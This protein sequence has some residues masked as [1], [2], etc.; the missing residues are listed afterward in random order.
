M[1]L[2]S[3]PSISSITVAMV[4]PNWFITVIILIEIIYQYYRSPQPTPTG[5]TGIATLHWFFM[6]YFSSLIL[7]SDSLFLIRLSRF[8]STFLLKCFFLS[9]SSQARAQVLAG[10][11]VRYVCVPVCL[12]VNQEIRRLSVLM[13]QGCKGCRSTTGRLNYPQQIK[14][15]NNLFFSF[16]IKCSW[17]MKNTYIK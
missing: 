17:I 12:T 15:S 13:L 8:P 2:I 4:Y 9:G 16:F 10:V 7:F 11:Q 14:N 1:L 5:D 6:F 3:L